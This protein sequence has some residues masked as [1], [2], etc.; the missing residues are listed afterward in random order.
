[1]QNYEAGYRAKVGTVYGVVDVYRRRFYGVPFQQFLADGSQITA[2]YGAEAYGVNVEAS[3]LPIDHLSLNFTGN[4]QHGTYTGF[5]SAGTGTNAAFDYTGNVLQRQPKIQFRFTP[6]YDLPVPWGDV[7]VFL[8]WTH[9]GL[10][11][12]DPGNTQPLPQ[13]DTLDAG[14]VSTIG[15]NFEVRL[16]GSNLTNAIGL[17]EG[18]ARVTTSGIVNGFEMARPI[19]GAEGNLQL[20]YKF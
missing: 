4:W 8:T 7:R 9:V 18:N 13:Y 16:Q 2:S 12:S 10:R 3:W 1:V 19:F 6:D 14:I 15:S 17:T 20:R 5:S 11:Y